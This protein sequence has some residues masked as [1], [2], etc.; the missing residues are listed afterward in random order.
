MPVV[1][2]SAVPGDAA[3]VRILDEEGRPVGA[4]FLTAKRDVLTCAHVVAVAV[5]LPE[6]TG[7]RPDGP[8]RLD[9]PLAARGR[10]LEARVEQWT[11]MQPDESGDIAVLRLLTDP[12]PARCRR[13]WSRTEPHRAARCAPSASLRAT[14]PVSGA[15]ACCGA[16]RPPGGSSTT[17]IRPASTR[18]DADSPGPRSGTWPAGWS[19]WWSP[20]TT[21]PADAPHT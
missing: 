2:D 14:T 18:S 13:R 10:V 15:S 11:P 9:F 17:R 20:S 19:G 16:G 6:G 7:E 1:A 4:G 12:R 3:V 21:S 8:V 5:G